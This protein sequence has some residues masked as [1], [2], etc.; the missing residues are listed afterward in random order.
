MKV[1]LRSEIVGEILPRIRLSIPRKAESR[2]EILV[3]E[4]KNTSAYF[5]SIPTNHKREKSS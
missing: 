2:L 1:V 5:G 3:D 4:L